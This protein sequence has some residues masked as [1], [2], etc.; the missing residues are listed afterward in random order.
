MRKDEQD[1]AKTQGM[2]ASKIRMSA[3][4]AGLSFYAAPYRKGF[5]LWE[6]VDLFRKLLVVSI[7]VFIADGTS[8]QLVVGLIFAVGGLVLQ[9]M[10]KPFKHPSENALAAVSQGILALAL[11]VGGLLRSNKAEVAAMMST[12]DV[13]SFVAGVYM[14][15]SGILLYVLAA[16]IWFGN[17]L[18][19]LCH[20]QTK[21]AKGSENV[22]L[23]VGAV[24]TN[25]EFTAVQETNLDNFRTD[26]T[27]AGNADDSEYLDIENDSKGKNGQESDD[28][29]DC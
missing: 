14:I 13:D 29:L 15:T 25:S 12:A 6:T 21:H 24:V 2:P 1:K 5:Y 26:A 20:P 10:Y 11:A 18:A 3:F 4:V 22:E 17:P 28:D 7:I 9:L 8:L 23:S 27:N 16:V 19:F